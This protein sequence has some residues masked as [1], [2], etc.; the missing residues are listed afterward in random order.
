LLSI[1]CAYCGLDPGAGDNKVIVDWKDI[2]KKNIKWGDTLACL[3]AEVEYNT[4][5]LLFLKDKGVS[6]CELQFFNYK[7]DT[8][9]DKW[10]K[11]S[12]SLRNNNDMIEE[13]NKQREEYKKFELPL[14]T[15][16]PKPTVEYRS[17]VQ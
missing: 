2:L 17:A 13:I 8:D 5:P 11:H 16:P 6:V 12:D 14:V 15:T 3:E 4:P 1:A 7:T 9:T 10:E